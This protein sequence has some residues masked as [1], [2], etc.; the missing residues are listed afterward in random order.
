MSPR[1][2]FLVAVAST[3]L[4]GYIAMG[5][6]LGRVMGDTTYGQLAVFNEVIRLVMEAYVEPVNLDRAMAGADHGL[7]EALDGDSAYLNAED[8]KIHQQAREPDADVGMLL[9]RRFGFLMVVSA[10]PGSP[11]EKA[12]LR[13]GDILKTIDGRH[14]RLLPVPVGERLLKGSPGSTLKL[15]VLRAKSDP[16]ELSLVRE[17]LAPTAPR[18]KVLADGVGYLQ[19]REFA[20]RVGEDVRA[21]VE[22]LK[23]SGARRLVLDLRG[24]AYG[25]PAEGVKVAEVFMKGG[26]VTKL[27]GRRVTE[28][29]MSADPAR[30]AWD[31]PMAVLVDTGTAG[32]GEIVA[33]ALLD[34][35]RSPVIGERTF[36]RAPVQKV[37]PLPEGGLI[38]TVAKYFSPKGTP[39]HGKGVEPSV[40]VDAPDE[41][42]SPPGM[43]V[44]DPILEKALEV[45]KAE[46]KKAA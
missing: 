2:R 10:R 15:N 31:L 22:A 16:L 46:P 6:L 32:P 24:A 41:E 30:A 27:A 43:D 45:L 25:R 37:V 4:I 40:P 38:L 13:P 36:G 39:I 1:S 28:E 8:F 19:V 33:A 18:G 20:A 44:G 35:G 5:S 21:E 12:G 34:A 11:A 26:V 17:R 9:T 29:V 23:R 3:A 42:T 7:T 14:S